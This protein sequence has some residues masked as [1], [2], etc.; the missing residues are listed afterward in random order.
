MKKL[1][2]LLILGLFPHFS[3]LA[4]EQPLEEIII[5]QFTGEPLF[6]GLGSWCNVALALRDSGLRKVAFPFDWI[7]SVDCE[8]FLEIFINDFEFFLDDEYLFV[9]NGYFWNSYYRLEFPHDYI[10]D[11][12]DR[13]IWAAFK[14]KYQ[15]RIRRF[16]ELENYRG[17]VYFIRSAFGYSDHPDRFYRCPENVSISDKYARRL[18]NV[19][20]KRFPY[21]DFDLIIIDFNQPNKKLDDNIYRFKDVPTLDSIKAFESKKQPKTKSF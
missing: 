4:N 3:M 21:L 16:Q 8:K 13:E 17:K 14:E 18:Y 9:K 10:Q 12:E 6:V 5:H 20:R 19:L 1:F 15:R 7:A 2:L 11:A